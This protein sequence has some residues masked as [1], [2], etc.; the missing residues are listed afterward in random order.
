MCK[1]LMMGLLTGLSLTALANPYSTTL[2]GA[3]IKERLDVA[4]ARKL[5]A[6]GIDGVELNLMN[7]KVLPAVAEA[8]ETRLLADREGL[9]ICSVI[10][11][12]FAFNEPE[13]YAVELA[14]AK[15]CVELTAAFGAP[16]MLLVPAGFYPEN[17]PKSPPYREVSYEW[18]PDTL[19]VM[20]VV[21]GDNGR[22][23]D[24]IRRQNNATA[25][26][27]RAVRELIPL[28]AEKG[29]VI[30]LENVSSRMWMKPDFYHSLVKSFK[31][32]WV[33]FY[34]DMGN[35]L[36][37]GDPLEWMAEFG[38][39]IVKVHLKDDVL[40]AARPWGQRQVAI[41]EGELDFKKLRDGLEKINYNGW[42]TVESDFRSDADHALILRR[43][44]AGEPVWK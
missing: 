13:K 20:S 21:K 36:N 3:L 2:K 35:S 29:V 33:K 28:A 6:I 17:G 42:V 8:R 7:F 27:I 39:D 26:A 23:T 15:R 34:F 12:W 22:Y 31:S 32:P 1:L 16:V 19:E 44:I 24:F 43:F 10:S 4:E 25:A 30:A 38:S 41:G 40:D 9:T 11:G 14:K 5:K 18:D 37:V